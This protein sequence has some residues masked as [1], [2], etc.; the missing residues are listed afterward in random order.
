M[1]VL[2]KI[3]PELRNLLVNGNFD[4]WQRGTT[5]SVTNSVNTYLADRFFAYRSG[6]NAFT[7]AQA[8]DTPTYAQSGYRS[9]FSALLTAG[10]GVAAGTGDVLQLFYR[11]EGNDFQAIQG[12]PIRVQF[13]VKSSVSGIY[14]FV[15]QSPNNPVRSYVAPYT[16]TSTNVWQK[17]TVDVVLDTASDTSYNFDQTTGLSLAF[18]LSSGSASQ[19]ATTNAWIT[20]DARATTGQVNWAGTTGAT[21]QLAQ[22]ALYPIQAGAG[23]TLPFA[24]A[25]R[26]IQQE[27]AMC[28]RYYWR[29]SD[30]DTTSTAN[31]FGAGLCTST[32]VAT[33]FIQFPTKMRSAPTAGFGG[34]MAILMANGL[35]AGLIGI[36]T[37]ASSTNQTSGRLTA[38]VSGTPLIAGN[39]TVLIKGTAADYVSFDAEL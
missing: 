10:T 39:A 29:S 11:M 6:F 4:F 28:Q 13:W 31:G 19:T 33:I 14:S 22:V 38:S 12:R 7:Y 32:S 24:R 27:L 21:F 15:I 1:A 8:T 34:G 17:V 18:T 2:L 25:G 16:I 26:T 35:P 37:L 3:I 9:R 5:V 36:S 23:V 30:D 20:A